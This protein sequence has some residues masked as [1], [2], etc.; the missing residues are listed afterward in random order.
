MTKSIK[1]YN[2]FI[3]L[4][5]FTIISC[6]SSSNDPEIVPEI[7][8]GEP[9]DFSLLAVE[10]NALDISLKPTFIWENSIDP[11]SGIIRYNFLLDT[12]NPPEILLFENIESTSLDLIT[13]LGLSK[14]Y[15]WQVEAKD[16]KNAITKSTVSTF[17]T[18][19]LLIPNSPE[20]ENAGFPIRNGHRCVVFKNKIWVIGGS[21]GGYLNDIWNSDN[22]IDWVLVTDSPNFS[23]RTGFTLTVFNNKMW[24]IAGYA[25]FRTNDV[26]SSED[27]INWIQVTPNADFPE[28]TEHSSLVY[29]NKLWVIGGSPKNQDSIF[30]NDVWY[31]ENGIEWVMATESAQFEPRS[32]HSSVVFDGKIWVIGGNIASS[33][34]IGDAWYSSDGVSWEKATS[35][36]N[37]FPGRVGQFSVVFDNKIWLF[38]GFRYGGS[39]YQNDIWFSTDGSDWYEVISNGPYTKRS[40]SDGAIFQDKIWMIAGGRHLNLSGS[41][42]TNDIW[43][44]GKKFN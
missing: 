41:Y 38:G 30:A 29:D 1:F 8:N 33:Q 31:T 5:A 13:P 35:E 26:W 19:D 9:S 20:V 16:E 22:G 39:G 15:Y 2:F 7:L 17:S 21:Y 37:V 44:F 10:N 3:S 36:N 34:P 18:V 12:I 11:E 28:R 40:G 42:N 14:K 23:G 4:L 25:G 43:S 27:G 32:D 24:L 6:S